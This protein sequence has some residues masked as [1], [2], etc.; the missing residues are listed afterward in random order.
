MKGKSFLLN[1]DSTFIFV[2][3]VYHKADWCLSKIDKLDIFSVIQLSCSK[4]SVCIWFWPYLSIFQVKER[5]DNEEDIVLV[6]T[7]VAKEEKKEE[8]VEKDSEVK[9]EGNLYVTSVEK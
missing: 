4:D 7:K 5:S 3:D 9:K 6:D 8:K 2:Q 1:K